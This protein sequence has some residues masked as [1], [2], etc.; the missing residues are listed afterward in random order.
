MLCAGFLC[1]RTLSNGIRGPNYTEFG[2]IRTKENQELAKS[3]NMELIPTVL[4]GIENDPVFAE[5][6]L[7]EN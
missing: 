2:I 7:S 3:K 5:F 1:L 4:S 6:E